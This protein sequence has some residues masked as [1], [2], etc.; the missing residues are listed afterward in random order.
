MRSTTLSPLAS[1]HS[2]R[3]TG[4][5]SLLATRHFFIVAALVLLLA[6]CAFSLDPSLDA[7]QY[8]HTSW[9][10]G[11]G[12][13]NDTTHTIVQTKD[14]YLWLATETGLRRFDG[15]RSVLWQPPA[16]EHLP[17]REI[18][19]LRV[20]RDGTLWIGTDK[21]LASWKNGK[22]THYPQLDGYDVPTLA[23]DHEGVVWAA[24]LRWEHAFWEPGRLGAI[25]A[26]NVQCIGSDAFSDSELPRFTRTAEGISG[27][28]RRMEYGDGSLLLRRGIHFARGC[29]VVQP[30]SSAGIL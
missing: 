26:G 22:L 14:G 19:D 17:G 8:A 3:F 5:F 2:P 4:S 13:A 9:K 29:W 21:G 10:I 23:E 28:E 7:S 15:V 6:R 1:D 27:W 18:R 20:S 30:W 24:G 16:G 25:K 12:V 11:E